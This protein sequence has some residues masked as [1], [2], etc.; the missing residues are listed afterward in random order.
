METDQNTVLVHRIPLSVMC[1]SYTEEG[2]IDYIE[3]KRG[4][5]GF[6]ERY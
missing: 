3:G 6:L 1:R 5:Y 4:R 2:V